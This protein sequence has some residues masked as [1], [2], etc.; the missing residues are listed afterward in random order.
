MINYNVTSSLLS[1][2]LRG[3]KWIV[4][5]YYP[6][7]VIFLKLIISFDSPVTFLIEHLA[8]GYIKYSISP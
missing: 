7:F 8:S 5:F 6:N 4:A 3:S 1:S 2:A